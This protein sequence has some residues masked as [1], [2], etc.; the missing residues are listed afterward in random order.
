MHYVDLVALLAIAQLIFFAVLVGR[1]RGKYGVK[2]PATVG[3]EAFE[4]A[5][6]VQMN[7]LELMVC[8][9]PAL[10][11]AAKYW[12]PQWVAGIGAVYL[13]GRIVYWLSYTRNPATRGPGFLLSM[14]P[15]LALL[16]AGLV[17]IARAAP[18]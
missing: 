16:I 17:A 12:S 1:A 9:L 5:Y 14:L 13:V 4:R 6:R 2:A 10:Y 7:T 15:T 3:H 18:G 8:F 11:I